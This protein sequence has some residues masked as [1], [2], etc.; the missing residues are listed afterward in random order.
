MPATW[1]ILQ[2]DLELI[3]RLKQSQNF[4]DF[5]EKFTDAF[6]R[7]TLNLA[8]TSFGQLLTYGNYPLIKSS[9]K[10]FLDFN[11]SIDTNIERLKISLDELLKTVNEINTETKTIALPTGIHPFLKKIISPTL[12]DLNKKIN[13]LDSLN[14]NTAENLE[15]SV[16]KFKNDISN[17][18]LELIP[19]I[20]LESAFIT[21]WSTAKF[22]PL[23]PIPP[24]ISPLF[25]ISILTPGIPGILSIA[26]KNAFK[27][28]DPGIAA[29]IITTALESHSKTVSGIYSGFIA[30]PTGP[31]PSPPI[32]WVGVI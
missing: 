19:Y 15:Q 1:V 14:P 24:T 31:I 26:F 13:S 18:N 28:K 10:S 9:I 11:R 29:T 6:S 16:E 30:S 21:F 23:P 22:S 17:L 32:P 2:K 8:T 25:G 12:N 5:S 4:S 3:F 20:F 27:S 7:S